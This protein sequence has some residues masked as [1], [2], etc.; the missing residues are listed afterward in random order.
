MQARQQ[1]SCSS[2]TGT[3]LLY[4]MH[5]HTLHACHNSNRRNQVVTG[6]LRQAYE[7]APQ[8]QTHTQKTS[9]KQCSKRSPTCNMQQRAQHTKEP[10]KGATSATH[11]SMVAHTSTLQ[12][13]CV[14]NASRP[15]STVSSPAHQLHAQATNRI[16]PP[17]NLARCKATAVCCFSTT[18]HCLACHAKRTPPFHS[19][20]P[21]TAV[22]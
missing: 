5:R 9:L 13:R 20:I 10:V 17:C 19:N 12:A 22:P 1:H 6:S 3:Q 8:V 2:C 21:H 7:P 11:A 15:T 16:A 18:Q 14:H 4:G